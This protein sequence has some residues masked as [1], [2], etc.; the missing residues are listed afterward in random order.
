[1]TQTVGFIGLGTMG[2]PM[3]RNLLAAGFALRVYNRTRRKAE[4]LAAQGATVVDSPAETADPDGTVVTMVANDQALRDV[5]LGEGGLAERLGRGGVHLSMSTVAPATSRSL[6]EEHRKAGAAYVAAPV[7][8]RPEA[9][10]ARKLW[11]CVSGPGDAQSRVAPLLRALGQGSFDLGEDPGAGDVVKLAGNFL[12]FCVIE[13]LGEALTF[14][15]KNGV[16]RA[17]AAHMLTQSMFNTPL[18][19]TYSKLLV[20]RDHERAGFRLV[21]ALK[22]LNLLQE[23]AYAGQTPMPFAN[24]VRDRMLSAVA[25]GRGQMDFSVLGRGAWEDAG[26]DKE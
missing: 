19:H 7:F 15:Q 20:E 8:G 14:A 18:Y 1:M 3:A 10:A 4:E 16:D 6:A 12:I 17:V 22:D 21:L 23:A 5:T 11:M 2:L 26:L 24:V 25:R 9:A 13:A